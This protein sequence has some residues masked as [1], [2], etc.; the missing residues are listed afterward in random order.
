MAASKQAP[1]PEETP[2]VGDTKPE[3]RAE[4]AKPVEEPKAQADT[5]V[6][7]PS[8]HTT[9]TH[10]PSGATFSLTPGV[11]VKL[12][13]SDAEALEAQGLGSTQGD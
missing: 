5:A 4:E 12:S 13:R 1:K 9:G 2:K 10:T 6:F 11:G 3:V 7:I 8:T